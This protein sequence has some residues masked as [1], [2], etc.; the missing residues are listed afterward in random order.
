MEITLKM[1]LDEKAKKALGIVKRLNEAGFIAYWVGGCVRDLLLNRHPN[2]YDIATNAVPEKVQEL[3]EKTIPVG[4]QFG[5]LLVV[6]GEDS[7]QVATFRSES[8]YRDGRHPGIITFGD[9]VNDAK[10]RDFTI[11]GLFYDPIKGE[12]I[13][14]VGGRKDIEQRL[15]RAIGNPEERFNEDYLRMLRAIRFAA[16]LDFEIERETFIAVQNN[17]EK[18]KLISA[19]RVRDELLKLFLPPHAARGLELLKN[20]GLLK[21]ILPEVYDMIGCEQ[22]PI[23]HP[24][25]CVYTHT[26]RMLE[27][28]PP[29]SSHIL[30]WSA[31][32]HDVGKPRVATRSQ[33]DD[34]LL[35]YEH[36]AVGAEMARQILERLKFPSDEIEDI[37]V[38][39][40]HHMQLK[41]APKMKKSTLRRMLARPTFPIEIE[42]HR[43]DCVASHRQLDIYEFLKQ[44]Q[45]EY[46]EKP[47]LPQPLITGEDL[48][49]LGFTEGVELGMVLKQIREKQ[50][51]DE[52]T[53][54]EQAIEFAKNLMKKS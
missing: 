46:S 36:D 49:K 14:Y 11:N 31:L 8:D 2:D 19:E 34:R 45:Q 24:E 30:V 44:K 25:G 26:L 5:V 39:I 38:C 13:D 50:L 43:L 17:A 1:N 33:S 29:D 52:I 6:I 47:P 9:P 41:D 18:I 10:R 16:Q 27:N 28:L 20:S 3:F 32:L 4:K 21:H 53:T 22:S 48:K 42:L 51:Q 7:F 54:R 15:I 35:F 23:Y 12:V 37:V 40:R